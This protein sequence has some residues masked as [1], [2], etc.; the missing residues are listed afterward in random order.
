[1]DVRRVNAIYVAWSH[2]RQWKN[3]QLEWV[4]GPERF[5]VFEMAPLVY[6]SSLGAQDHM[7]GQAMQMPSRS[8]AVAS[9]VSLRDASIGFTGNFY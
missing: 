5:V 1:M 7:T 4:A 3:E 8:Y 2:G 6:V 9:K